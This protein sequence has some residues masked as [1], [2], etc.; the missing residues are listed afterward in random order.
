MIGGLTHACEPFSH[1]AASWAGPSRP[2]SG[3]DGPRAA[4]LPC[5]GRAGARHGPAVRA[6]R[7]GLHPRRLVHALLPAIRRRPLERRPWPTGGAA[8][9]VAH[10]PRRVRPH[11]RPPSWHLCRPS[12]AQHGHCRGPVPADPPLLAENP[13]PGSC[14]RVGR[15]SRA[16]SS[17][18]RWASTTPSQVSLLLLLL[19]GLA[20]V[21]A[22]DRHG[23]GAVRGRAV[24]RL[25]PQLRGHP[26]CGS[27]R[28]VRRA[29]G[30]PARRAVANHVRATRAPRG[31]RRLDARSHAAPRARVVQL[32]PRLRVSFRV[33]HRLQTSGS[34]VS[35]WASPSR[36]PWRSSP[37]ARSSAVSAPARSWL[38]LMLTG[39]AIIVLGTLAFA[40][41]PMDPIALGD[42]AN[43]V[44]SV[45]AACLWAALGLVVWRWRHAAGVVVTVAFLALSLTARTATSI[46][47]E[48]GRDTVNVLSAVHERF[49][50]PPSGVIVV[51]PGPLYHHDITGL[52]GEVREATAAFAAA[53]AAGGGGGAR[54]ELRLDYRPF[55]GTFS[56]RSK[57]GDR[58]G[59]LVLGGPG[60]EAG[61]R[62][63]L[64]HAGDEQAGG[65]IGVHVAAE[66]A[67]D[68][69]DE[70]V[71]LHLLDA[72][73]PR[74]GR[75]RCAS[76]ARAGRASGRRSSRCSGVCSSGWLRKNTKRPPGREHAADLGDG[77]VDGVDVLEHEAG[78]DRVER[79]R[80]RTAARPRRRGR[81]PGRPAPVAGLGTWAHVGSTPTTR[82][83]PSGTASRATWPS[84]LP[85]SS[86]R[87]GA[88]ELL[89][90]PAAGSAPRTRGRRPR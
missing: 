19:G 9:R 7:P 75:A 30:P 79:R 50:T 54:P 28:P 73:C 87:R 71:L 41:D 81:T 2:M 89:A 53:A 65:A 21:T 77:V 17:W 35:V 45:G 42:R 12:G 6:A 37:A 26:A 3:A 62:G 59:R 84:P 83:A 80:R 86:T 63:G 76:T 52:I 13:R 46:T 14:R 29:V 1:P 16:S 78:D 38:P 20:L 23:S 18:S 10:L 69:R 36:W 70:H 48:Q 5:G 40:R 22:T 60:E 25:R 31:H 24:R 43:V 47:P 74:P 68:E 67:V 72:T 15:S 85:T 27:C 82:P 51:G 39:L 56:A 11:R 58:G 61:R 44:S 90:P 64:L 88:G 32:L 34:R 8:R 4:P 57:T 49:P 55:L 33:G 66:R